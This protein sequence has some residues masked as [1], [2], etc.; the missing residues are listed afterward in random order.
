MKQ[1]C[2]NSSAPAIET[3]TRFDHLRAPSHPFTLSTTLT[4]PVYEILYKLQPSLS[5]QYTLPGI[6]EY[7]RL[8]LASGQVVYTE[9][10]NLQLCV[11]AEVVDPRLGTKD[12]TN[13]FYFTFSTKEP[14][15]PIMPQTY[16]GEGAVQ[17]EWF[18]GRGGG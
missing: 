5:T 13:V 6:S 8:P 16:H 12:L 1:Q 18:E 15:K 4:F 14:V 2:L 17:W 11:S 7:N 9:G 10:N 3:D